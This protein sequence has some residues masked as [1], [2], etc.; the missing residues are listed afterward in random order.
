[1]PVTRVNC[2][3]CGQPI[4][5][6]INQLFDLNQDPAAKQKLLSGAANLISCPN[7]GYQGPVSTSIVYHDPQKE[8]LLT[9]LPPDI[10]RPREEQE[11]AIGGLIQQVVN[12]LP[13]EK[14]KAYLLQPQQVLTM[15]GLMERILEAD[16][17][18]KEM[19][20]AQQERVR[21]IQRLLTV[22]DESL[23]EAVEEETELFDQDF[24]E[25]LA[26]LVEASAAAG[27][28]ATAQRLVDLQRQILPLTDYGRQIQEQ[29]A[30][31]EAAMESLRQVGQ[32]LT[33][34]KLLD[35][36]IE[37]PNDIR[38][39][40]LVSLTRP[41][42]DYQFFQM[43]SEKID[44]ANDEEKKR[45]NELRGKLLEITREIDAQQERRKEVAR[46]NLETLLQVDDP[47][48]AVLQNIQAIDE[49]FVE[50]LNSELEKARQE[51]N[52]ERS[53]KLNKIQD[54]LRQAST[55]PELELIEELIQLP[56]AEAIKERMVA[57]SD[58]ITQE[59]LDLMTNIMG[60]NQEESEITEKLQ[61]IYRTALRLNMQANLKA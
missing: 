5:A 13:Q 25:I 58:Q 61:T 10:N 20:D 24:F 4:T 12:N 43:L 17:I 39:S 14:R 48:T 60:Q 15:Q 29:S 34:E 50:V 16:G 45:L 33:R 41:G 21:L 3:N 31:V 8:L 51:G 2:P 57:E 32:G 53:A 27:D 37:A 22:S 40:A 38:L 1:M 54:V 26:R 28:N 9:Y 55:P 42:L 46:Q 11:R 59:F 35:L 6:E 36:I 18:T 56:D 44:R 19:I 47:E 52:L 23:A 7:C 49:A 30:E